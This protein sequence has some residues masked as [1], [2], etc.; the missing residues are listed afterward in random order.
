MTPA[1][2]TAKKAKIRH[3]IHEYAHDPGAESYGLEAATKLQLD[4]AQVFKT[5]VVSLDG[6]QLAVGIIPVE[7]QLSMKLMARAAGAKKAEMADK[8]LVQRS[9]GYVLGGVS[10]LGQKKPLPTFLHDS[11]KA[12]ESLFVSAGRRGLEIELTPLDLLALTR[13]NFANLCQ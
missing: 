11:A 12:H 3:T 7:S 6:K 13:G 5:L 2:N 1:I 9:T 8:Q 4:P 10:P